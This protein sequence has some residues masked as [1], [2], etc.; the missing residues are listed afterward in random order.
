[1]RAEDYDFPSPALMNI[2]NNKSPGSAE[3]VVTVYLKI[4]KNTWW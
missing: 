1:M 2:V 3:M 4:Q